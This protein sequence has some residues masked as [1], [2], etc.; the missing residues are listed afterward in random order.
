MRCH[1]PPY[2]AGCELQELA[3][4]SHTFC[5]APIFATNVAYKEAAQEFQEPSCLP[6]YLKFTVYILVKPYRQCW[7]EVASYVCTNLE[8]SDFVSVPFGHAH[9]L[10]T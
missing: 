4:Q 8:T 5:T 10:I 9:K 6:L 2:G 1:V 3:K 7:C